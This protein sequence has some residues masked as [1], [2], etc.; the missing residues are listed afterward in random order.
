MRC[1]DVG[2]QRDAGA[3]GW[4]ESVRRWADEEAGE[5]LRL[6]YVAL[7]RAQSQVV[8]WWAP[9]K[10]AMSSPLHRLLMRPE[11]GPTVPGAPAVPGDDEVVALFS[12]W[13]QRG[14]PVPEAALWGDPPPVPPRPEVGHL[15]ARHFERAVDTAWRRTSYSAL[16]ATLTAEPATGAAGLPGG[17]AGSGATVGSEPEVTP[18]DDEPDG[19]A[20]A[21]AP[22]TAADEPGTAAPVPPEL[23][24][25]SPMAALPVGA[26]FGSLV[27]AVLEHTDPHAPDLHAELLGH[28][29][30]QLVWWPVDVD[31]EALATAL[32]AVCESPLGGAAPG[33]RLRDVG[34]RD[35]LREMDFELPLSGG[36]LALG[37]AG[38]PAAQVRLGDLAPLLRRHLADDDPVRGYATALEQPALGDQPLRG[39]LT[40]SVD[41]VLRTPGPDGPRYVIVDYKTNWLGPID[42]PLT[43]HAYRP[44]ALDAAM[45][46]SDYPLQA[47]L[48]AVVLHRFLRWRQPGY[49]PERHLGG[50][51]YL[52]L[53]GMC[54]AQTPWVDGEPCGIFRWTPPVALL[55]AVSDLLDG[56]AS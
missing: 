48:Y 10:N 12:A 42:E 26:T 33:L 17:P 5:W 50:V 43:A 53:R 15:E 51:L 13:A 30:E 55:E 32:V 2:G 11:G 49:D 40:G 35:R 45:V 28:V 14:G 31:P 24:L 1:L 37:D 29:V 47:L 44:E 8:C 38:D 46:H 54:G 19:P 25:A 41:V 52:Y 7:T 56:G 3:E 23:Q 9:T 27:H 6:L 36:D 18:R 16:T 20:T 34:L 21:T 22:P 39:Y 4:G